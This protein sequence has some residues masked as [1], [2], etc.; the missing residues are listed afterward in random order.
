MPAERI[1]TLLPS[2]TE[3]VCELGLQDKL[4]GVT[5]ECDYPAGV[6]ALPHVTR[7]AIAPGLSSGEIDQAVRSHLTEQTALYS[8][9]EPLLTSLA[10]DLIVTQAL[11]EVCAVSEN[12]VLAVMQRLPAS[13]RLVNLEP[14]TLGEV[15]DTVLLVGESAGY[16]DRA[17]RYV[18]DLKARVSAV[19][20]KTSRIPAADRPTVGFL[21]WLDPLFNAG[22]W[23]PEIIEMAGGVDAFGN[24]HQPSATMADDKL[25]ESDPDVLIVALCGFDEARAHA[26]LE[27]FSE[28]VPW[29]DLKAVQAGRVHIL[30]GNALFSRPGPRL[31]DSLEILTNL[32]HP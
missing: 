15:F 9:D 23:T 31:V 32:L 17:T 14:M 25:F 22:H 30:D 10:P 6:E 20:E 11:C 4:V 28:R 27:A 12:D 21:E 18:T 29:Q 5:H 24:K 8:I 16:P 2:A 19:C 7:S 1:V 26:D 3:I 13:T